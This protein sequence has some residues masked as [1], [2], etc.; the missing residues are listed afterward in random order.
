MHFFIQNIYQNF[1]MVIFILFMTKHYMIKNS[2][3]DKILLDVLNKKI[4]EM[5]N[6]Y[7]L[8]VVS[9]VLKI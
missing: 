6:K 7:I 2:K 9:N 3:N 1:V 5:A 4:S 8:S